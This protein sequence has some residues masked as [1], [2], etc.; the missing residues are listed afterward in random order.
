MPSTRQRRLGAFVFAAVALALAAFAVPAAAGD[1]SSLP[2]TWGPRDAHFRP[3]DA[4]SIW[5]MPLGASPRLVP[6][7][8]PTLTRGFVDQGWIIKTTTADP[9]VKQYR[10]YSWRDRCNP[11]STLVERSSVRFPAE[12]IIRDA[13]QNDAG[14]WNTPNFNGVIVDPDGRTLRPIATACR[15]QVGGPLYGWG[16]ATYDLYGD[17]RLGA[18]GGSGLA[19]HGGMIRPGELTDSAPIAHVLDL[20]LHLDEYGYSAG[21]PSS[22][23]RWPASRCDAYGTQSGRYRGSNPAFVPGALLAVPRTMTADTL[24]VQSVAGRKILWAMQHYGGYVTD[25]SAWDANGLKVDSA[26]RADIAAFETSQVRAEFG[27]IVA[28]ARI[29]DDNA[30]GNVGGAGARVAPRHVNQWKAGAGSGTGQSGSGVTTTVPPTR[31]ATTQSEGD[32]LR[33]YRAYF[34]REPDVS[35]GNYWLG[36]H[37]DGHSLDA[38]AGWFSQSPEFTSR[39]RNVSNAGFVTA[40]YRNVLGR[41]PDPSGFAYWTGQLDRGTLT[42]PAMVRWVAANTEFRKRFPYEAR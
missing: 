4:S 12:L 19:A 34:G 11:S 35:G 8:Y 26:A 2:A 24:G 20:I 37:A 32:V 17:G 40:V 31:R 15:D 1:S 33:L 9:S 42:Q 6:T 39:Y 41:V 18:H 22:C 13:S 30:P 21:G 25:D 36:V 5:N 23:F 7:G 10:P 27:R 28:A 3:H 14:H 29:V 16:K 38:I